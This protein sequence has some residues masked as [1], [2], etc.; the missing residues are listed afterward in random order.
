MDGTRTPAPTEKPVVLTI[1]GSDSGGGAGIQ[2]DLKTIEATG[3]FGTSAVTAVTAQNTTGVASSHVLPVEELA[4]QIEAVTDDFDVR[5]VKTGMLA[6][7]EVVETVTQRVADLSCPVVVDPVMVAATGDRLLTEAAESAYEDLLAAA[8]LATPNADEA[9]VLTGSEPEDE[10]EARAAG[11]EII[12]LGA[13]AAL[14]KGGH[15]PGDAVTDVLVADSGTEVFSHPRIDTDATHGSGCTLSAAIATHLASGAP[16]STAVE[17]GVDF[18]ERAV[19]YHHSVGSGPGAVHHLVDLRDDAV[20]DTVAE[21][22]QDAVDRLVAEDVS[23]AIPQVGM[24]VVAATPYAET[25]AD[26]AAVEGRLT[27]AV[28]GVARGRGVRFGASSHV[29]RFLLAAREHRPDLA[30]AANCRFDA[31]VE[32]ALER[33]DWTVAEYDRDAEPES[34][35]STMQWA[36]TEVFADGADPV[37][38]I[39]RG[40]VGKE[41]MM[42]IVATSPETVVSQLIEAADELRER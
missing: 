6:T 21:S 2:A 13:D 27:R 30:A 39:D 5:A 15:M 34:A 40:D 26:I 41:P 17:R 22:V 10:A 18:M 9:A 11:Q 37:A 8:T 24:N 38:I 25:T 28:S 7:T 20:R 12:A 36:A 35:E 4:A 32:S 3:G 1:A 42:K 14:V 16:L 29:A 19:R 33:L 23:P 31:T